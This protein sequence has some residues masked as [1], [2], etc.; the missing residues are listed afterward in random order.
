[1]NQDKPNV[2]IELDISLDLI[3][4][5]VETLKISNQCLD[6]SIVVKDIKA[7]IITAIKNELKRTYE[8]KKPFI[9]HNCFIPYCQ[10]RHGHI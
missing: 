4:M 10:P 8:A 5:I 7:Y 6:N 3:N 2:S 1:M 9:W